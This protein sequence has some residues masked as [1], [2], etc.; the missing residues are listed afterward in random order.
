MRTGAPAPVPV[1]SPRGAWAGDRWWLPGASVALGAALVGGS[2]TE[3]WYAY[4]AAGC[5]DPGAKFECLG[6]TLVGGAAAAVLGPLLLWIAY[7]R[8]GVRRALLGVLVAGAVAFC[9]LALVEL[10]VQVGVLLGRERTYDDPSGPAVGG[11]LGLAVLA[12]GLAFAGPR[13]VVRAVVAALTL[14][15][16]VGTVLAL[17]APV[18]REATRLEL[19]RAEVPLL[20]ADGW[21]PYGS[22]V[23]EAGDVSYDV[24]PVGWPGY[25]FE[26]VSIAVRRSTDTFAD[27]CSFRACATEGDITYELPEE[28]GGR[29]AWQV[30]DGVL[31]TAQ[32]YGNPTD[33][34]ALDPVDAL[35]GMTEVGVE[36]WA[37][38]TFTDR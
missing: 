22:N 4:E 8:A 11:F 23:D 20:V 5:S 30:V 26:G 19:E 28:G 32:T 38:R 36:E 13:R 27:T 34:P 17:Q 9:L 31:V 10:V 18:A 3:A 15:A 25:G 1:R 24:V 33:V 37:A 2:V 7:R 29:T 6:E 35:R 12:G 16:L 21:Q 14:A